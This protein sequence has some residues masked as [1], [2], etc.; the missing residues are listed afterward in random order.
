MDAVLKIILA[1]IN[2]APYCP[3]KTKFGMRR[4]NRTHTTARWWKC[5]ISKIQY[6]GRPPF[7]KLLYLHISAATC[8]NFMDTCGHKFY[9]RRGNVT[10]K[11]EIP[12]FKMADGRQIEN[13]FLLITGLHHARLRRNLEFGG[14]I[15]RT[16]RLDD[17]ACV[18]VCVCVRTP[19]CAVLG[20]N[21]LQV[22]CYCN[23]ITILS[24]L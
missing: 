24:N 11:S 23:E 15:S 5:R 18:R 1:I 2:S 13:N 8:P 16:R 14:I 3:I 19:V 20:S 7:W 17:D 9:P 12:K 6:G 10:K 22:T 21:A 4:H